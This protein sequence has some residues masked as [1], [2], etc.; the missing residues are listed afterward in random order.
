MRENG[1]NERGAERERRGELKERLTDLQKE[2]ERI[3]P[4]ECHLSIRNILLY[5]LRTLKLRDCTVAGLKC[6]LCDF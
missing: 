3:E 2:E 5:T 4:E 6:L 1:E